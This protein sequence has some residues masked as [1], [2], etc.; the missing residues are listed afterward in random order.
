T[1]FAERWVLLVFS[2]W[3]VALA[4]ID[5]GRRLMLRRRAARAFDA[6]D[7][8]LGNVARLVHHI[9]ARGGDESREQSADEAALIPFA[10]LSLVVRT[11]GRAEPAPVVVGLPAPA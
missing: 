9:A 1:V 3:Q 5:A 8:A 10:L 6:I 7:H 11:V 2:R 4:R